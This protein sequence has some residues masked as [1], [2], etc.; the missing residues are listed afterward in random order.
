MLEA[1]EVASGEELALPAAL[2][3]VMAGPLA[4]SA[5]L[6]GPVLTDAPEPVLRL[7]PARE[8]APT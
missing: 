5:L 2:L 4:L 8:R 6:A 3:T 1:R 7:E